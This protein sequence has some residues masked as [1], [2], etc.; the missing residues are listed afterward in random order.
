MIEEKDPLARVKS[1][2]YDLVGNMKT[3]TDAKGQTLTFDYA[4]RKLVKVTYPNGMTDAYGYDA[5]GRRISATNANTTIAYTYDALNRLKT[6]TNQKYS[7][8]A[9]L[10]Y[11]AIGNRTQMKTPGSTVNYT[12]DG[13][14][15]LTTI[16]DSFFGTFR[17]AYDAM[18]R[19]TSLTYPN[20]VTTSYDYDKAYRMTS[21]VTKDSLGT[22]IDAWAYQYDAIGNRTAKTDMNGAS[23]TYAYD[24][25]Y[26][27]ALATY[28]NGTSEKFTYDDVGN[29]LTRTTETGAMTA[30]SYDVANRLLNATGET[31]AYDLNGNL[32]SRTNSRGTS[33]LTYDF[34]NRLTNVTGPDGTETN[35]YGADGQRV[36]LAGTSIENGQVRVFNDS[37]GNPILDWGGDNR[38]WTYRLYAPGVDEPLA[39]YRRTNNRTSFLHRDGIGSIT[40][41]TGTTAQVFYRATYSAFGRMTRTADSQGII[42]TRLGFTGRESSVGDLMYYRARHYDHGLGRFLQADA[43]RGQAPHPPS[44][45]RYA[46]VHNNPV[47]L[48]DP[49]GQVAGGVIVA[50][51]AAYGAALGAYYGSD[52][53]PWS[54]GVNMAV[55]AAIGAAVAMIEIIAPGMSFGLGMNIN[56]HIFRAIATSTAELTIFSRVFRM[57]V[58]GLHYGAHTGGVRLWHLHLLGATLLGGPW[59]IVGVIIILLLFALITW[60]VARTIYFIAAFME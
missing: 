34:N 59:A 40:A 5:F 47:N 24:S 57:V 3:K 55:G 52:A 13:K 18:D 45:H 17:F 11:D 20:N 29:R 46:Y 53:F 48:V 35:L 16:A 32:T 30:Y 51:A 58:F 14:N 41:V 9:E 42:Q 50:A 43:Y 8:V 54:R 39:E 56:F 6:I 1:Y 15:R 23:E 37:D 12:Y 2:T 60:S 27:L 25:V 31:F 33:T 4:G 10:S 49:S 44:L 21:L 19:R 7:L 28:A 36:D 38:I 22:V 26:R